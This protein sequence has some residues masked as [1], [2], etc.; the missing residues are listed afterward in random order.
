ML[1]SCWKQWYKPEVG[2]CLGWWSGYSARLGE[3]D[4][5]E[6]ITGGAWAFGKGGVLKYLPIRS[7]EAAGSRHELSCKE[8]IIQGWSGTERDQPQLRDRA[9]GRMNVSSCCMLTILICYFILP[10]ADWRCTPSQPAFGFHPINWEINPTQG[11]QRGNKGQ[12]EAP[13]VKESL[14]SA[15]SYVEDP[16]GIARWLTN[17]S[18]SF[19]Y[20]HF[21]YGK[22]PYRFQCDKS[23]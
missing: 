6:W 1:S 23:N 11:E 2:E 9:G 4:G 21:V 5:Y 15:D 20:C 18:A 22:S 14:T 7:A 19:F 16:G 3:E 17:K 8:V 12:L 13:D 10:T